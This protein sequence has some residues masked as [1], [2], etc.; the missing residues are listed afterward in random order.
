MDRTWQSDDESAAPMVPDDKAK[1]AMTAY[2][3]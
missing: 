2:R 1:A 3:I